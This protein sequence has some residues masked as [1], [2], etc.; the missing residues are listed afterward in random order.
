MNKRINTLRE[1]SRILFQKY[2]MNKQNNAQLY[3]SYN[4]DHDLKKNE[5][6]LEINEN[7]LESN[8]LGYDWISNNLENKMQINVESVD[9][10]RLEKLQ[11]FRETHVLECFEETKKQEPEKIKQN[12][13]CIHTYSI[14]ERL[15]PYAINTDEK[16]KSVCPICDSTDSPDIVRVSVPKNVIKPSPVKLKSVNDSEPSYNLN[17]HCDPK[18]HIGRKPKSFEKYNID[19]KSNVKN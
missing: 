11:K 4:I 5:D 17:Q 16:G 7:K 19:L 10:D 8:L 14:N 2:Q 9:N 13:E 6:V 3:K 1:K 12:H 15:I 18:V